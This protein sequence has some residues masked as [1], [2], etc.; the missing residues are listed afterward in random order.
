M[1]RRTASTAAGRFFCGTNGCASFLEIDPESGLPT[2]Q[3][4]GFVR[5]VH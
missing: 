1:R 2:C 5:R 3:I 4:C